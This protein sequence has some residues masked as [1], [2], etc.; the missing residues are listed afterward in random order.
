MQRI[1]VQ[2]GYAGM[3]ISSGIYDNSIDLVKICL[4]YSVYQ[5]AFV[6]G[7][8][9]IDFYAFFFTVLR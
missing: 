5:G 1:S 7:L 4:L 3:G 9:K 6:V 2:K 8:K